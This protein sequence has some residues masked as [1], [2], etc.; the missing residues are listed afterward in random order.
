MGEVGHSTDECLTLKHKVQNLLDTRAF[1]FSIA[2]PNVKENPLP[3][4]EDRVNAIDEGTLEE[5]G[6]GPQE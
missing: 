1:A 3:E 4:H 5:M 2:Q 6:P